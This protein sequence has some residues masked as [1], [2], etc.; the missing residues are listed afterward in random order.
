MLSDDAR[1]TM[2]PEPFEFQGPRAIAEYFHS[3]G[4][5]GQT[6]SSCR[7]EPTTSP[8]SAITSQIRTPTSIGASGIMV[9]TCGRAN[10]A[11]TRFGDRACSPFSAC[12]V[13]FPVANQRRQTIFRAT[14]TR[15]A[16]S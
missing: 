1:F 6:S 9:L 14:S 13:P 12:H 5:L 11:I 15:R 7:P 3:R 16:V 10:S 8:R 2:P 4:F